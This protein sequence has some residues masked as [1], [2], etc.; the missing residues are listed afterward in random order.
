MI[1]TIARIPNPVLVDGAVDILQTLIGNLTYERNGDTLPLI[2][3]VAPKAEIH[4]EKKIP[5][6][7][8][9]NNR[10]KSLV[11]ND[12]ERCQSFFLLHSDTPNDRQNA[13][14]LYELSLVVWLFE[15]K[16]QRTAIN[17]KEYIIRE[18][19][20]L[21]NNRK[22]LLINVYDIYRQADKVWEGMNHDSF[23]PN[24]NPYDSFRIKF[25]M[26]WETECGVPFVI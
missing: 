22:E 12:R 21:F 1:Q 19:L 7:R 2:S 5:E 10:Y 4:E 17:I 6:F 16:F 3:Y 14:R 23:Q 9:E 24:R 25:D 15:D 18:I 20:L 13:T 8:I 26:V 11:P